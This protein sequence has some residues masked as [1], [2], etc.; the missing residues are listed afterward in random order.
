MVFPSLC[1][2]T[3]EFE[4]DPLIFV[5]SFCPNT[6][7]LFAKTKKIVYLVVWKILYKCKYLLLSNSMSQ[8]NL[9]Q[10]EYYWCIYQQKVCRWSKLLGCFISEHK[11]ESRTDGRYRDKSASSAHRHAEA[12]KVWCFEVSPDNTLARKQNKHFQCKL[13]AWHIM[14]WWR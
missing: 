14:V 12:V 11:I 1:K 4:V 13:D 2:P 8:F 5:I 3:G 9:S 6:R 7:V 10:R